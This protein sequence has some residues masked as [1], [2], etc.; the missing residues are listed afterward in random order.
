MARIRG[1]SPRAAFGVEVVPGG[2][3]EDPL[4]EPCV[5]RGVRL[6]VEVVA[7][8]PLAAKSYRSLPGVHYGTP[9]E[10]FGFLAP[11]GR[12][13]P[14]RIA[15]DFLAA[16]ADLFGLSARARGL[17]LRRVIESL[18]AAHV[19]FSQH[20]AGH[21]VHRA[22]VTVHIGRD[23]RAYLAKNRAMPKHLLPEAAK[24]KRSIRQARARALRA[25][26]ATARTTRVVG[27][28][29]TT[30]FPRREKLVLAHKVRL[31]RTKPRE[32]WIVYVDAKTGAVLSRFD[33]L[34]SASGRARV[35]DPNP[36]AAL[37]DH[38]RVLTASGRPKRRHPDRAYRIVSIGGLDGTGRLDGR[39]VSTRLTKDRVKSATHEFVFHAHQ[40]GFD[41]ANVY[42][43]L[44]RTIRRL[45]A[46][47]Y[48]G[49]RAILRA[50]LEV[51]AHGTR[52]DNSWYSPGLRQLTFGTG[53]VDDA[54]DG[55][56]ILHEFGH[57]L[58]DAIVPDF[59]QSPQAAAIGEGFGDYWA[60][61]SFFDVKP[62]R[63]RTSVMCW[64]SVLNDENDPPCLRRVDSEL[65]FESFDPEGG[66]H[67]NGVIW[68]ATLWDVRKAIGAAR[69]D[70]V[71][72]ESH[73]QLDGFTTFARA[74]R[75]ILDANR[76]LHASRDHAKLRKV[77]Q[78][79]G[80]GPL[81]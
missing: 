27:D 47:G 40:A 9:K 80:I 50:P 54:E 66:E 19:I 33:N 53:G 64:D 60:A 74:A 73:F 23:G 44:D 7:L 6:R 56:T 4:R 46:M 67:E 59:G 76:N 16:N 63:Y 5:P 24:P 26:H 37:G 72:V 36:V 52:E 38:G 77:F 61:S 21:P 78:E 22:Y 10:I 49:R 32:E 51:D 18:G 75:A 34:A 15:R 28:V 57:A 35:F 58:Q 13:G 42:F 17:K 29:E 1:V 55:E 11:R 68:S 8:K 45:E 43:H 3:F 81:I 79:R 69:A 25:I 71:I 62:V 31:H 14:E 2:H 48:R 30:W 41:E 39:R 70:R 20:H 12:G 65:T